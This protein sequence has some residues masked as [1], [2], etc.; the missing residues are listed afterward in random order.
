MIQ[1][2]LLNR[3]RIFSKFDKLGNYELTTS[4][5]LSVLAFFTLCFYNL[6]RLGF[7]SHHS[8]IYSIGGIISFI[9]MTPWAYSILFKNKSSESLSGES[10]LITLAALIVIILTSFTVDYIGFFALHLLIGLGYLF[11]LSG[12]ITF[13]RTQKIYFSVIFFL[14]SSLFSLWFFGRV[15]SSYLSPLAFENFV[16]GKA[17]HD[18][19]FH[20]SVLEMFKTFGHA[21]T[22]LNGAPHFSYH[23]GSHWIF[24]RFSVLFNV[25]SVKTYNLIYPVIF[26]PLF[27]K[28][29]FIFANDIFQLYAKGKSIVKPG[30]IFLMVFIISHIGFLPYSFTANW[31][32]WESWIESESY[33]LSLFFF[34][35]FSSIVLYS[36]SQ[37]NKLKQKIFLF[38]S[39]SLLLPLLGLLKIS[40]LVIAVVVYSYIFFRLKLFKNG[41][42]LLI[43]AG[44]LLFSF[45]IY[46]VT[47]PVEIVGEEKDNFYLFH[48]LK[49][50]T[51]NNWKGF[52]FYIHYFFTF[53][54][55]YL[56]LKELKISSK[57]F[58]SY[59]TSNRLLDVEILIL[60]SIIGFLPGTIL[61]IDGGSAYYFSDIQSR[62]SIALLLFFVLKDS[63]KQKVFIQFTKRISLLIP[64][65]GILTLSNVFFQFEKAVNSN[66]KSR[67]ELTNLYT[68]EVEYMKEV[69]YDILEFISGK[70]SELNSKIREMINLPAKGLAV[71]PKYTLLNN[72]QK[73]GN[74]HKDEKKKLCIYVPKSNTLYWKSINNA[75]KITPFFIPALT[76]VNSL[77]GLPDT[78]K[79][80]EYGFSA[81]RDSYN[82][83]TFVQPD[84]NSICKYSKAQLEE[85]IIMLDSTGKFKVLDCK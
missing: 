48:F 21:S 43:M 40:L 2:K 4:L 35:L 19:M 1:I 50:Y 80:Y 52:F 73:I 14:L 55:I 71:S 49:R 32:N 20:S 59:L 62:I 70:K 67:L 68:G 84:I 38:C 29:T 18:T 12:L 56:R 78:I 74:L 10:A 7:E 72:L 58:T 57:N 37:K 65:I 79:S 13:L 36:F 85:T 23:W 26:L 77:A 63:F 6:A 39:V 31:A 51:L 64:I 83:Y 82:D 81:Y 16:I 27:F 53:L 30:L 25:S 76:G 15:Y 61:K 11:F 45:Y 9:L 3:L 47:I 46:K 33:S 66:F 8:E 54:Y 5:F 42:N 69:P 44:L 17:T 75:E 24:S 22:G 41:Y 34:F 28:G 60:I